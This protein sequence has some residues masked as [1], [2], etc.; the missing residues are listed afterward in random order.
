[1]RVKSI[2]IDGTAPVLQHG[3]IMISPTSHPLPLTVYGSKGALEHLSSAFVAESH[4]GSNPSSD[5]VDQTN[6]PADLQRNPSRD[7]SGSAE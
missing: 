5:G 7:Y 3:D 1:M 6:P 4:Q 2:E